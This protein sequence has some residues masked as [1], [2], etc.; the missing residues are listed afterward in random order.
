MLTHYINLEVH[1]GSKEEG[2]QF[3]VTGLGNEELILGYPWLSTFE[4]QFN[5]TNGEI[6]TQYL[7]VIIT[8]LDWKMLCIQPA[9]MGLISGDE[10]KRLTQIRWAKIIKELWQVMPCPRLSKT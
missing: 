1:T 4:P 6:N 5:W 9:I 8:S 3:L 10:A 7:P 2:M